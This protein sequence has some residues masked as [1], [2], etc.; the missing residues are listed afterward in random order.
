MTR[1]AD[2]LISRSWPIEPP[3]GPD[4]DA[5]YIVRLLDEAGESRDLIVAFAAPSSLTS[6]GYAEEI[7]RKVRD[8][9][10]LPGHVVVATTGA[11]RIVQAG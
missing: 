9:P 3:S 2:W 8:Q 1:Q 4:H 6:V 7:A 5:A 11:L 10:E